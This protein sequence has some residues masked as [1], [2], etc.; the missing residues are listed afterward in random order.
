MLVNYNFTLLKC[1]KC[2]KTYRL[3]PGEKYEKLEVECDCDKKSEKPKRQ[4]KKKE[5]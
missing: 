5:A 3:L 1:D 4:Y 2:Q